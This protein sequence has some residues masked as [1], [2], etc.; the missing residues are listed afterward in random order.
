MIIAI[1]PI[2]GGAFNPARHYGAII[3]SF[4]FKE[5]SWIYL[6]DFQGAIAGGYTYKFLQLE[7]IKYD[8]NEVDLKIN[9]EIELKI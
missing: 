2:S 3:G 1:Y 4:K 5:L 6:F 7:E 8:S 9:P